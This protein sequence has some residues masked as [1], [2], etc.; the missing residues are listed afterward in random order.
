MPKDDLN[1]AFV[2]LGWN[3]ENNFLL[4]RIRS[5]DGKR[6]AIAA[7]GQFKKFPSTISFVRGDEVILFMRQCNLCS[8][9]VQMKKLSKSFGLRIG[10]SLP[11][12]DWSHILVQKAQAAVALDFA[13]INTILS[14]CQDHVLDYLFQQIGQLGNHLQ[15]C[16]PDV[17]Y[18][19]EYD[20]KNNTDLLKTVATYLIC[21][22][23]AVQTADLLF[24]HR[25]TIQYRINRI[26]ELTNID[27][28]DP[29]TR[30]YIML[31]CRMFQ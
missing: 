23:N 27:L 15:L 22:R 16:H 12:V 21:E 11:F 20:I 18:L 26:K 8:Y 31:S 14:F 29:D 24:V 9:E 6:L 7:G 28:E 10:I 5:N 2:T 1:W 25:N 17:S 4:L 3:E 19:H 13:S 30:L